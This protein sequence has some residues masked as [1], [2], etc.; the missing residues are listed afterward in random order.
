MNTEN[1]AYI[2]RNVPVDIWN[3]SVVM[4]LVKEN[5]E[6]CEN[7]IYSSKCMTRFI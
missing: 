1:I 7:V 6:N 2:V 5:R 4:F 3:K